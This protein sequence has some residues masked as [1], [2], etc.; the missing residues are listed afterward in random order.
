MT[1]LERFLWLFFFLVNYLTAL[2]CMLGVEYFRVFNG[3]MGGTVL[4]VY[5]A[6]CFLFNDTCVKP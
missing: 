2:I 5:D 3:L 6:F 4:C 1:G